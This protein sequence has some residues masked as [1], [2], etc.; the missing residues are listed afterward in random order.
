MATILSNTLENTDLIVNKLRQKEVV[1]FPTDT[2]YGLSAIANNSEAILKVYNYKNRPLSKPLIILLHNIKQAAELFEVNDTFYLL[3][4]R[5][6]PGGLTLILNKRADAKIHPLCSNYTNKQGFRI[7]NNEICLK[8]L[9]DLNEPVVAT[10]ANLSSQVS[11]TTAEQVRQSFIDKDL[12]ILNDDKNIAGIES[13]IL[14]ITE[15]KNI[16]L[17]RQ[18]AIGLSQLE[19]LN[20]KININCKNY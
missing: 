6:L 18:G 4:E 17:L 12:L 7:P 20:L 3:A 14:D 9:A 2:V 5:F 11:P 15:E 1:V 16:M 8:L 19:D 10:S 13:T